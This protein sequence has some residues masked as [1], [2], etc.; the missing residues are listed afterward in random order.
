MP[1]TIPVAKVKVRPVHA[2]HPDFSWSKDSQ[3]ILD[4][5]IAKTKAK[6]GSILET[7]LGPQTSLPNSRLENTRFTAE[8]HGLIHAVW[9][10]YSR[11]HH[12]V[13]RPEDVW[14][15]ILVQFS[16]YVNAHAE[17]LRSSFVAHKGKKALILRAP[18][19]VDMGKMTRNMT[20]L[21]DQN[22]VDPTLCEWIL[23][24]FTTTTLDDEAVATAIMMGTLKQYFEYLYDATTCGVP[25]VTLLGEQSDW[26]DIQRRLEKL[27]EYG[28]E[29]TMFCAM[30]RPILH[31]MVASYTQGPG[32]ADVVDF[33]GRMVDRDMGSGLDI[34]NGWIAA[35]CFWDADGKC[36]VDE[37][38]RSLLAKK[39]KPEAPTFKTKTQ[40]HN[41]EM[42]GI[43]YHFVDFT[44]IPVS[45][46]TVP[47][48][49]LSPWD[50][51]IPAQLL[52][53][54]VGY[55]ATKQVFYPYNGPERAG[56][57]GQSLT[58]RSKKRASSIFRKSLSFHFKGQS[59]GKEGSKGEEKLAKGNPT[60]S[61]SKSEEL[62][63]ETSPEKT[64]PGDHIDNMTAGEQ[65]NT[66]RPVAAWWMYRD[67]VGKNSKA[68]RPDFYLDGMANRWNGQA[69]TGTV[70]P[71]GS[72]TVKQG[73]PSD[74]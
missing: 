57:A 12:L 67:P 28:E 20:K 74:L 70:L 52:A 30:L 31:F 29:P 40:W 54:L 26:E 8:D 11:H 63:P 10:A 51:K 44:L 22:I 43:P 24:S 46:V 5:H 38:C 49:Y 23:P 13:I 2:T 4:G 59:S 27:E 39:P 58:G 9:A 34:L 37:R 6:S 66:L 18:G 14:F 1:V 41:L 32:E 36:L 21:I 73:L 47:V 72:V 62:A 3:A 42:L 64:A 19:E 71:D 45:Y 60:I 69:S 55:E 50:E 61:R 17:D 48:T 25:S 16:F 15:A 35:F 65:I 68:S 56:N 53:G 7:E 33:W